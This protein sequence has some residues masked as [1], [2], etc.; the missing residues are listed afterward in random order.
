MTLPA[1]TTID[2]YTLVRCIGQGG[3]GAVY[4]ARHTLVGKRCT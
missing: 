3:M 4:E 1:G 2:K